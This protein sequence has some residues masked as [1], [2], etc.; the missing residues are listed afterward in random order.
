[1]KWKQLFVA[2]HEKLEERDETFE[3]IRA[4]MIDSKFTEEDADFI[5]LLLD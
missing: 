4:E 5:V 2:K 3:A 1:V